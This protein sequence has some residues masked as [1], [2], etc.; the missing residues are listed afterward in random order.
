MPSALSHSHTAPCVM[1]DRIALD[2]HPTFM[3]QSPT[4]CQKIV[5]WAPPV[6]PASI[7]ACIT[8]SRPTARLSSFRRVGQEST[9]EHHKGKSQPEGLGRNDGS[10]E[11]TDFGCTA[12]AN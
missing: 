2:Q 4:T 1:L 8:R 10:H 12:P 7:N 6:D 5:G 9:R 11:G 3:F